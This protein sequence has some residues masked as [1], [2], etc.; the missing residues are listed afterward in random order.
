MQDSCIEKA[1]VYE[2]CM[3]AFSFFP[4]SNLPH[5]FLKTQ[6]YLLHLTHFELEEENGEIKVYLSACCIGNHSAF[7]VSSC[8]LAGGML[9]S[10]SICLSEV[11]TCVSDYN[12][13]LA[14]KATQTLL[15][16]SGKSV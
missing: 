4:T 15:V 12:F 1:R 16:F 14:I 10:I 6:L 9:W 5:S 11:G 3:A 2:K 8:S 7:S 13:L